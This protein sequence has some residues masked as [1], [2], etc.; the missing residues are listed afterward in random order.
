MFERT[1]SIRIDLINNVRSNKKIKK[2]KI[3][4]KKEDKYKERFERISEERKDHIL[5]E[6]D[7]NGDGE[8]NDDERAVLRQRMEKYRKNK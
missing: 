4:Q 2:N 1:I 6:F 3:E 8:L 7:S 5:S